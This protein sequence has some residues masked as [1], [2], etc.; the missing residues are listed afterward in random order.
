MEIF[1]V[2]GIEPG[3]IPWQRAICIGSRSFYSGLRFDDNSQGFREG[4]DCVGK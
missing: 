1:D 2:T 3:E 4:S